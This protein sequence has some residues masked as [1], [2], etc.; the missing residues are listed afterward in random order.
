ME[1]F[2]DYIRQF[3]AVSANDALILQKYARYASI[4]VGDYFLS[5]GQTCR[6]VGFILTGVFRVFVLTEED[7]E[8][9]R[10][11]PS[12][13]HLMI[14]PESYLNKKPTQE[15]WEA[16]TDVTYIYWELRD[17]LVMKPLFSNWQ[18]VIGPMTH[19]ILWSESKERLE[20]MNDTATVR[21]EKFIDRYPHLASRVPLRYIANFLCIA[22]QSLSRIRQKRGEKI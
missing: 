5:P 1:P 16:I 8:M 4:N 3:G 19:H 2:L 10:G 6:Q 7:K 20:M 17:I 11:F 12:E 14:D 18:G 13:Y 21:Y 15:Y 9:T 22:P